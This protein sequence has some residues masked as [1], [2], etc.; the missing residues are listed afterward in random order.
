MLYK[1]FSSIFL[2]DFY[3]LTMSYAYWQKGLQNTEAIFHFNFRKNPFSGGFI[4]FAGLETIVQYIVADQFLSNENVEFLASQ[5][6]SEGKPL[7]D[8]EFILYLS[9]LNFNDCTIYAVK[10][11]TVVF[12]FEPVIRVE[13]PIIKC[14]ILE[15]LFLNVI[16]FQSLIAT[17]AARICMAAGED[18]VIEL[19]MR[20]A[21]GVD[22]ALSA[23][24][25]AFI[26]GCVGTSNI[27][28]GKE[29]GI[30]V[31]GTQ[32]H[33][34]IMFFG[35]E[36]KAFDEY[37]DVFTDNTF[38]VDTY[39]TM[40][41]VN[42]AIFIGKQLQKVGKKL[43]A[44]RLDSGD[45]SYLSI[46]AREKLDA[47]G[48]SDTKIIVSNELDEHIIASIKQEGCAI[49]CWGVGTKMVTGGET[50]A[51]S[52]VY[53]LAAIK[54]EDDTQWQLKMK[55]SEQV[56]KTSLPGKQ[57]VKRFYDRRAQQYIYDMVVSEFINEPYGQMHV[58]H[59]DVVIKIDKNLEVINLLEPI[60]QGA[61]LVY[62]F[63]KLESLQMF[64]KQELKRL[65]TSLKRFINPDYYKIGIESQLDK[66]QKDFINSV[67]KRANDKN[68]A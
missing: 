40:E 23:S 31:K 36:K 35:D 57:Q 32:S 59:S 30:P 68:S 66:Q 22:G 18:E 10:E 56:E 20:H 64:V 7:F 17:K 58:I 47:A 19:G 27:I 44:I 49:D 48:F 1:D 61:K 16:G 39:S 24:R 21:H 52:C 25:A 53:K 15:T 38:L 9:T 63:P 34:W 3:N 50:S 51:A 42:N 41:G 11:G 43:V 28:A 60:T 12:P 4:I 14:Q 65:P 26:G 6:D 45:L 54:K 5:K 13:G 62:N 8:K 37:S 55:L 67:K 2:T 29:F 33:S 46:K